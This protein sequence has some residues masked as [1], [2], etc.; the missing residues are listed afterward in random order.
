MKYSQKLTIEIQMSE[1]YQFAKPALGI[2]KKQLSEAIKNEMMNC[3]YGIVNGDSG[4]N[5]FDWKR[6][7]YRELIDRGFIEQTELGIK[8]YGKL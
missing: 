8:N 5:A 3:W 4:G 1:F 6:K 2:S 7:L